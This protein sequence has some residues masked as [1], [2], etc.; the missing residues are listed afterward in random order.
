MIFTKITHLKDTQQLRMNL[1]IEGEIKGPN[2][3]PLQR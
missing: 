2:L 3:R 1:K